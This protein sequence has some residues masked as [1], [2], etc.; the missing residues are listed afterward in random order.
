VLVLEH[1]DWRKAI[2]TLTRV[3]TSRVFVIIQEN[4][5][6]LP[7]STTRTLPGSMAVLQG[8]KRDLLAKSEVQREFRHDG[9]E[10][11]STTVREV[12]DGKKM[13]ALEFERT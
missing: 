4:P 6:H 11:R 10:L 1:V 7:A 3:T 12:L 9:F 2:A 5:P 8:I 13:I